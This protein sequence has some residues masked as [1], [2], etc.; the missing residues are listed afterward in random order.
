MAI[1]CCFERYEKKY[2]LTLSQQRFLL[3][4]MTPYMKKDAYGEY[5]ICNIYYD[6]DDYRL[7]RAS[8]EKPVYKEK[9]RVRSYGVPQEDGKVFVELKKK[10]DG[11]VYKR[12]ITMDIQ[13][14]EPF[15][16]GELPSENFGQIGREIGYFQSFYQTVPKVF[17]GYD[18]LAF[19]GIDDPQLRITFDTNLRWRDTDVDLRL[20]DHGAP[21]ALPC[22]DVLMEVKIPGACPLWLSHLL[23]DA[24]AFP[25]SF[26]KYGEAYLACEGKAAPKAYRE[27]VAFDEAMRGEQERSRDW[28]QDGQLLELSSSTRAADT[29]VA[30]SLASQLSNIVIGA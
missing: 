9:L 5:T 18:R 24:Q 12:R 13:N 22:G 8:L 7:I 6:T 2:C 17:I 1:Q 26:S 16:S 3:E 19:A 28:P 29:A 4:R 30:N 25:T 15:L 11:V 23:S 21:I 10:F 20:G 27:Q 14:V